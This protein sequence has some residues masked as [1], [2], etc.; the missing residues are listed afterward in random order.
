MEILQQLGELFLESVPTI[1]IVLLFY[2]FLKWSFF[3]PIQKAMA[4]RSAKIE[5]AKAE[6]AAAEAD[7]QK[8]L[9]SYE[10]ALR[11]ARVEIFTQQEEVRK[12]VLEERAKLLRTMRARVQEDVAA[13]KLRIEK[14]FMAAK[15]EVELQ[16]PALAGEIVRGI[17][18]HP[19]SS[20][21]GGLP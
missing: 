20:P 10:E 1:V 21:G 6:A 13:A 14:E 11:K 8:E 18:N 5:G 16:T 4:D 15:K 17:L 9:G 12:V 3:G 19:L 7:A 2:F